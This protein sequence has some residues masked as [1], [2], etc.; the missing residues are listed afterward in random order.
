MQLRRRCNYALVCMASASRMQAC[1]ANASPE[2]LNQ[3]AYEQ[4]GCKAPSAD[5]QPES[6]QESKPSNKPEPPNRPNPKPANYPDPY[7][8]THTHTHT[9][10]PHTHTPHTQTQTHRQSLQPQQPTANRL[11]GFRPK[12]V[13][14]H[15]M[16]PLTWAS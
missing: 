5:P 4:L 3:E 1:E 16:V 15:L 9:R 2:T 14:K 8:H 6:P 11:L 7:T 12:S 10:T 13:S